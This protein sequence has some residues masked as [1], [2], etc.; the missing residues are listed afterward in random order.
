MLIFL[1]LGGS[2]ITNKNIPFS[3]RKDTLRRLAAEISEALDT[4][5]ELKLLIGHGSGLAT[6]PLHNLER[7]LA[8]GQRKIGLDFRKYGG[9]HTN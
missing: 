7:T 5:P 6:Q 2:L 9:P 4:N 8:S 3:A 1:K